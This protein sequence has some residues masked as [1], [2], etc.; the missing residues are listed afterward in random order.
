MFEPGLVRPCLLRCVHRTPGAPSS[1]GSARWR[2]LIRPASPPDFLRYCRPAR[3]DAS[4]CA[5]FRPGAIP[6]RDSVFFTPGNG[7][8][9]SS[10]HFETDKEPCIPVLFPDGHQEVL[11][12]PDVL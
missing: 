8:C 5:E 4:T 3:P 7:A 10:P 12:W 1:Q 11:G 6:P 9:V 2:G